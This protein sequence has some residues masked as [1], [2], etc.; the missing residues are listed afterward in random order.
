MPY[1]Y[2]ALVTTLS[3]VTY[4]YT[5]AMVGRARGKFKLDA[6]ATTGHPDF[7]RVFRVQQNTLENLALFLPALWLFAVYVSDLWA[8][9]IGAV[10]ILGRFVYAQGYYAQASKR[11]T[12]FIVSLGAS[13]VLVIGALIGIVIRMLK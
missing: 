4:F 1:H 6:P 7:E 2:T 9:I 3:L 8:A 5:T 13:G 11:G 12:G 10:W